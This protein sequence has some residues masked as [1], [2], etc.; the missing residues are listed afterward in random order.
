MKGVYLDP[1]WNTNVVGIFIIFKSMVLCEIRFSR[2][3]NTLLCYHSNLDFEATCSAEWITINTYKIGLGTLPR[4]DKRHKAKSKA[5]NAW[6]RSRIARFQTD[7]SFCV[8]QWTQNRGETTGNKKSYFSHYSCGASKSST[9]ARYGGSCCCHMWMLD[10]R[11]MCNFL[12]VVYE[13][14]FFTA[15]IFFLQH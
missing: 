13:V 7:L 1:L 8:P 3:F 9:A 4:N 10:Q 15:T 14:C 6:I 2:Q 12:K 5:G 11:R